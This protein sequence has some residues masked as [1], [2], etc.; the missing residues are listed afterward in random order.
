MALH[1]DIGKMRGRFHSQIQFRDWWGE[2]CT[3]GQSGVTEGAGVNFGALADLVGLLSG[4]MPLW[5]SCAGIQKKEVG[6]GQW[7]NAPPHL[8]H[9]NAFQL[10][11][12]LYF[13]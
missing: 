5:G 2:L 3:K 4:R 11:S 1:C 8:G 7:K 9:V 13:L 10:R 12:S 6:L